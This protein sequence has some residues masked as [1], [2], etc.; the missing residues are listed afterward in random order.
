[1]SLYI[2]YVAYKGRIQGPA[3]TSPSTLGT[4]CLRWAGLFQA[5]ACK[6]SHVCFNH[7]NMALIN[8]L[9][10]Q[11]NHGTEHGT[12]LRKQAQL[13]EED[14][15]RLSKKKKQHSLQQ[16]LK[17]QHSL[18]QVLTKKAFYEVQ[19][20]YIYTYTHS[21]SKLH[22]LIK[23]DLY[24]LNAN[25]TNSTKFSEAN[26]KLCMTSSAS[27]RPCDMSRGCQM[28]Q[29]PP[30]GLDDESTGTVGKSHFIIRLHLMTNNTIHFSNK[31]IR[32]YT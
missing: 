6:S 2:F 12:L 13:K 24:S 18:Q 21:I 5:L 10:L 29:T 11:R 4:I 15:I 8:C 19:H 30:Q 27:L 7:F 1:M 20:I 32:F 3:R 25:V 22:P 9:V 26:M 17:K 14:S 31:A 16:V 28:T 23:K